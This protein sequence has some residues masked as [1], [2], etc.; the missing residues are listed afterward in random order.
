MT[1][2]GDAMRLAGKIGVIAGPTVL[3]GAAIIGLRAFSPPP[4]AAAGDTDTRAKHLDA[5]SVRHLKAV[6]R[7]SA[8]TDGK[9]PS[10][11]VSATSR[12]AAIE[13][14]ASD[15]SWVDD[16][17]C[18]QRA[19]QGAGILYAA[20]A[21]ATGA[22]QARSGSAAIAVLRGPFANAD[23]NFHAATAF[24]GDDGSIQVFD[25]LS[26]SAPQSL[27]SWARS[28]GHDVDDVEYVAPWEQV[29]SHRDEPDD[30]SQPLY[31]VEMNRPWSDEWLAKNTRKTDD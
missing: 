15:I 17:W 29:E 1:R 24:L 14:M 16:G 7:S 18:Y 28:L 26:S 13:R 31:P 12:E 10:A 21:E 4:T 30:R 3:V 22:A 6:A 11:E 27:D 20:D 19:M 23:W 5:G 25:G 8:D 9:P 2:Q